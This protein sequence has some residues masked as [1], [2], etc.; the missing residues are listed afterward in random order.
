MNTHDL[1]VFTGPPLRVVSGNQL[2]CCFDTCLSTDA[3]S[4]S[5]GTDEAETAASVPLSPAM[6]AINMEVSVTEQQ[7]LA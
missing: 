7:T 5:V 6:E 3:A 4:S 2:S 1:F